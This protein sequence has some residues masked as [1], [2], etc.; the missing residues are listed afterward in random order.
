MESYISFIDGVIYKLYV[1]CYIYYYNKYNNHECINSVSCFIAQKIS[2]LYSFSCHIA[3]KISCLNSISCH[4]AQKNSWLNSF[5]CHI[6]QKISW[7]KSFSCHIAQ[8]ISWSNSVSCLS[9]LK[10]KAGLNMKNFFTITEI[11]FLG[12][13]S[14]YIIFVFLFWVNNMHL[15]LSINNI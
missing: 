2:W 12:Y 10:F 1:M 4:I 11:Y 7:L 8:K 5:S 6:A 3:E 14:K 13:Q 9:V 15:T